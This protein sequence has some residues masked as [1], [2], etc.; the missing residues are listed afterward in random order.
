MTIAGTVSA[1]TDLTYD[2]NAKEATFN[3]TSGE[4]YG[5]AVTI[6]Y[7]GNNVNVT[8]AG[9]TATAVLPSG[10]NYAWADDTA[11][12]ATFKISPKDVEI[13]S[14]QELTKTYDGEPVDPSS[15][16][17][18]PNGVDGQP[19]VLTV[20][21][22]GG[23]TILNAGSYTVTAVLAQGQP[24]YTAEQ[25][26][27]KYSVSKAD[28]TVNPTADV[29]GALYTSD[30]LYK[31]ELNLAADDTPGT[32]SWDEGQ[33]LI[34]GEQGYNWT[35]VPT[36]EVNYNGATGV[37]R[38]TAVQAALTDIR[39][40]LSDVTEYDAYDAFDRDGIVVEAVYGDVVRAVGD[41]ELSFSSGTEDR[42]VAGEITVTVSYGDGGASFEE[43]FVIVVA[44]LVVAKPDVGDTTFE[45]NGETITLP[46]AES[47]YYTITGN[48]GFGV[49]SYQATVSLVDADNT[50]WADGSVDD[51]SISWAIT[52]PVSA[53]EVVAAIMA[54]DGV[55]WQNAEEFLDLE[56]RYGALDASEKTA[57]ATAKLA[58]LKAQYDALRNAAFDDIEAAHEV[59]AKSLG[60][61]L[62]AAA[63]GLSAAAIALAIAKRR[64]I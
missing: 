37:I 45:D 10:D 64:S 19:L 26:V 30:D 33:R 44:K 16:F 8:E 40:T 59:T 60:R 41:Y 58:T 1:P 49:G 7:S 25:A 63:A 38:L 23:A 34:A 57:E 55:T 56:A 54:M 31:I 51:I 21:V 12:S 46:I 43:S 18:A 47:E 35:F 20:T 62:A 36:D 2:G 42:L 29:Q 15:L 53:D 50:V 27:A 52:E 5:D 6:E 4:L 32:V 17:P 48:T 22:D 11:P 9:F 39:V 14:I 28:P 13:E 3:L 24:N 61:A